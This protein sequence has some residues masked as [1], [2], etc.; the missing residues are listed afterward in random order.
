MEEAAEEEGEE[1]AA[2][3]A[4]AVEAEEEE[5]LVR[6]PSLKRAPGADLEGSAGSVAAAALALRAKGVAPAAPEALQS[7]SSP[8]AALALPAT[9]R[10]EA[11]THSHAPAA[12]RHR[13]ELGAEMALRDFLAALQLPESAAMA[14]KVVRADAEV[15]EET[16]VW[17]VRAVTAVAEPGGPSCS[18]ARFLARQEDSSTRLAV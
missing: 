1:Q 14:D 9:S 13:A 11:P 18:K 7:S 2:L 4:G 8:R 10:C 12:C 15:K 5:A 3:P 6:S 17:Q 16:A